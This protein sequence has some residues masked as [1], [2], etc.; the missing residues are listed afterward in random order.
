MK[1]D[2][3]C[4][5]Y[6]AE[7]YIEHLI[8]GFANQINIEINKV[9]FAI[10]EWE[11]MQNI[12]NRIIAHNYDFFIVKSE[13]FSHSLTREKA[14]FDH[15]KSEI[16]IMISQDIKFINNNCFSLLAKEIN[17]K[18]V[19]AYGRQ[20][21]SKKNIE[22]YIRK[23]NYG[24]VSMIVG[25][26]DI[27]DLQLT[28]FFSSDAF[29]AY[30]RPTF[31]KLGGYDHVHMMM[32]EDMY[33]AKKVLDEGYYKAYAA[34]AIVEHSHK[35]TLKQLYV[36]YFE[37]GV[38]FSEHPEFDNYKTTDSG[39]RLAIYVLK[40]AIKQ[41]NF[42]VLLRWLPDMASRYLGMRKGKACYRKG[43]VKSH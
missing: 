2:I 28:A 25:K 9:V 43:K 15:C 4:P 39:R 36:R 29:S 41:F 16:V 34:D 18:V 31:L 32:S 33:Y 20:I 10:T 23:K 5:L 12:I 24:N 37:T 11:G 26:E 30:H 42:L 8:N 21:C 19:Y 7:N 1:I 35:Y 27:S 13:E 3:V 14:I 17:E 6:K 40:Q 38:W 22:Y